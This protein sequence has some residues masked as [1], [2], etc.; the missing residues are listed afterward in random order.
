MKIFFLASLLILALQSFHATPALAKAPDVDEDYV[1]IA[2]LGDSRGEGKGG[3]EGVNSAV[4]AK[5]FSM[6]REKKPQALFFSGDLT[7]GLEEEDEE[8]YDKEETSSPSVKQGK[9]PGDHWEQAGFVYDGIAFK[10]SLENFSSL[11]KTHLGPFVPLYPLMGNHEAVGPDALKIFRD[12]FGI[13]HEAFLDS[14]YLAYTVEIG[15]N[16]FIILATDYYSRDENKLIEHTLSGEQK[17]WLEKT[18]REKSSQ[19]SSLFVIG[20]EPAFSVL[21]E[22][23]MQPA[24]LDR[25]PDARDAFWAILK[26]YGVKA[27][28]CS[29]EHLYNLSKHDEVWQIISGG[30]GAP[31]APLNVG[32]YF[33][34]ALL[35]IPIKSGAPP[36]LIITSIDGVV[37]QDML[38]Q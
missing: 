36:R 13:T 38:L 8:N 33:H 25:T 3:D 14:P 35:Q 5:L 12:H 27:Y 2:I 1:T 28:I 26:K 9:L 7:L 22:T 17:A 37:Q 6:I 4:L 16:L 11:Q 15:K 21:W 19:F 34:Y 23:K 10:K 31:L 29:H 20:H 30:A 18:L 24:G 32:G